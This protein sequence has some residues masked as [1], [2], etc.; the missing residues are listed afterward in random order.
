MRVGNIRHFCHHRA[1]L[2]HLHPRYFSVCV[3]VLVGRPQHHDTATSGVDSS[4]L[5]NRDNFGLCVGEL[6][7]VSRLV[8]LYKILRWEIHSW[9]RR[10]A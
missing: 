9:W 7:T 10:P 5:R 1:F 3:G 6:A 8:F 2:E 4:D